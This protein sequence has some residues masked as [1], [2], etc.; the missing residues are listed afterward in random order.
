MNNNL[1]KR[2]QA[3]PSYTKSTKERQEI[4][5]KSVIENFFKRIHPTQNFDSEQSWTKK[6]QIQARVS[7]ST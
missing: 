3:K 5:L 6:L 2:K 1:L 4:S 7:S